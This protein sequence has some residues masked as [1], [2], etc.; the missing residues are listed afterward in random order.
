MPNQPGDVFVSRRTF[1]RRIG[2]AA[3]VFAA[4]QVI[5][6]CS[7][8]SAASLTQNVDEAAKLIALNSPAAPQDTLRVGLL[9]PQSQIYPAV[10]ANFRAGMDLFLAQRSSAD[11]PISLIAHDPSVL[12]RISGWGWTP[13]LQPVSHTRVMPMD[14]F[15]DHFLSAFGSRTSGQ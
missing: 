12:Q 7:N 8:S 1:L 14:G 9:L 3:S 2:A 10:G 13:G 5:S 6:A 15:R 4:G 11:R